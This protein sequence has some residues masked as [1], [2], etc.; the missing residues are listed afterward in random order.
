MS[1]E[2]YYK[3]PWNAQVILPH[4]SVMQIWSLV[5][6]RNIISSDTPTTLEYT[7]VTCNFE[8]LLNENFLLSFNLWK[9][10]LNS[11]Y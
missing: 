3:L 6:A 5:I 7:I 8:D 9:L 11:F 2:K 10:K 1:T 4:I